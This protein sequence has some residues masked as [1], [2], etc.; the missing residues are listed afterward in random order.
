MSRLKVTLPFSSIVGVSRSV[1]ASIS[2][3]V[4]LLPSTM[5]TVWPL[6]ALSIRRR[7][8]SSTARVPPASTVM[9]ALSPVRALPFTAS[10][11][12]FPN[13]AEPPLAMVILPLSAMVILPPV[14]VKS[15]VSLSVPLAMLM[16]PALV[17]PP[18]VIV[19]V[20]PPRF[21]S[22]VRLEPILKD[23]LFG[24]SSSP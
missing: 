20:Y 5:L 7:A 1:L 23:F 16:L 11:L 6:L 13:F 24:P 2:F 19:K 12:S 15:F 8:L 22:T 14:T 3:Q 21:M 17:F 4:A 10:R 9:A 18:S